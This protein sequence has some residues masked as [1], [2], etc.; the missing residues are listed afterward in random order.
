MNDSTLAPDYLDS[1]YQLLKNTVKDILD[2]NQGTGQMY[3][4]KLKIPLQIVCSKL[5]GLFDSSS[6]QSLNEVD[7]SLKNTSVCQKI[8]VDIMILFWESYFS[9]YMV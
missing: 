2:N 7:T 4:L 5:D 6:M 3:Y 9:K 1:S 8:L